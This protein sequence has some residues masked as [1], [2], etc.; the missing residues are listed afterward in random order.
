MVVN[1]K[2]K[3]SLMYPSPTQVDSVGNPYPDLASFP[4]NTFN[5]SA[6]PIEYQLTEKDVYRF[7]LLTY[8]VYQNYGFYDDFTAWISN[9]PFISTDDNFE[10]V[11]LLFNKSDIDTWYL[12]N[13]K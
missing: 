11:V 5:P 13:I 10:K 1:S 4:I 12:Q 3:Y 9:I 7:D 6:K 2:N 8:Q